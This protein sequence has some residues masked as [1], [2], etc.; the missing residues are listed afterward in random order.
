MASDPHARDWIVNDAPRETCLALSHELGLSPLTARILYNRGIRDVEAADAFLN[1]SLKNMHDP[2]L[3][4]DMRKA[5]REVLRAIDAGHK[6]VVHGDYDVDGI[7]SVS[8]LYGFLRDL[9]ANVEYYIP[10]RTQDGYGL[11]IE[12]VRRFSAT[13]TDLIITTDCGISNVD[14]VRLARQLGMRTIIVDHH[15]VPIILPPAEAILNPLQ[16]D[17]AFPFKGLAAVGVTFNFVVALR[18]ELRR[19]G[20]FGIVPEPDLRTFLDLVALGTVADVVPLVDENRIFVRL[21]LEVLSSRRRAGISA[22]MDRAAVEVG[23]INARTISFRLAPRI[24]A[25]GRMSDASMCVELLTTSSYGRATELAEQLEQLNTAR[26]GEEREILQA[27]MQQAEDQIELNRRAL[28]VA[29]DDWNRGVLG[30]VASRLMEKFHRP[31]FLMGIEDG[32][33]KGSA[34]SI[35]GINIVEVLDRVSDLLASFGGHSAAAGL[36]LESVNLEAFRDRVDASI[37]SVFDDGRIPRPRLKI[38]SEVELGEIDDQF[39]RDLHRLAPF[40][41]GNPEPILLARGLKALNVRVVSNKHLR[42]RFRDDSGS[43]DGFGFAMRDTVELMSEPVAIAFVPRLS[44]GRDA[45]FEIQLKGVRLSTHI[46]ERG[47]AE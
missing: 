30:I 24:N 19:R 21:G 22:L 37:A 39:I 38:D 25:A 13:K 3:M 18:S 41:S 33:A 4:K 8:V 34:R 40:G 5:V 15:T 44:S 16:K 2:F 47:V 12:T 17:C 43:I 28:V 45:Q 7:S 11:N 36:S 20:V 6:I 42:A 46:D 31:A 9:G 35:D 14:E 32:L 1:P 23:P 10:V 26:Q 29:G 27:A